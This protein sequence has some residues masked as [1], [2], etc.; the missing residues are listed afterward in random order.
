ML[1]EVGWVCEWS[2]RWFDTWYSDPVSF[3]NVFE[4]VNYF[5]LN[6]EV[7]PNPV[8]DTFLYHKYLKQSVINYL[9][10]YNTTQNMGDTL[11]E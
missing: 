1:R 2:E 8:G 3:L 11:Q 6:Y 7:N 5:P 4:P 10:Q 9:Q